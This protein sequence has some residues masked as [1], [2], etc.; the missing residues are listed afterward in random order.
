[1]T[2]TKSNPMMGPV[3][4]YVR[5]VRNSLM[6]AGYTWKQIMEIMPPASRR[7][8]EGLLMGARYNNDLDLWTVTQ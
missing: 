3:P 1:M 5:E 8:G 2:D 6:K 7:S 4:D